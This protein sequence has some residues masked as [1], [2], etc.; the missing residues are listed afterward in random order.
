[1]NVINSMAMVYI[2][3]NVTIAELL[4]NFDAIMVIARQDKREII[5]KY[6]EIT[7][8]SYSPDRYDRS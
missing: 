4:A 6:N 8:D 5:G 3:N 2:V 1:M 7:T